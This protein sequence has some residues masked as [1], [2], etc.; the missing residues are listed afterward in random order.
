MIYI[1]YTMTAAGFADIYTLTP[2][3]CGPQGL[4]A[5]ISKIPHGYGI[6]ITYPYAKMCKNSAMG[7]T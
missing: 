5:Y 4:G 6:T 1:T 7:D 2:R 3:T